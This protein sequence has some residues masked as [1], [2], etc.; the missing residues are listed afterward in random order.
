MSLEE[1]IEVHINPPGIE[2]QKVVGSSNI[3][4]SF[5][6]TIRNNLDL[7]LGK[8]TIKQRENIIHVFA[9]GRKLLF[10][11]LYSWTDLSL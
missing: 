4:G 5:G 7:K 9:R 1:G 2:W 10:D 3:G 8:L 6:L 11:Y